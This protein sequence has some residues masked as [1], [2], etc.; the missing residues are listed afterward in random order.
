LVT[1]SRTRSCV[2]ASTWSGELR[3]RDTVAVETPARRA[4]SFA[5]QRRSGRA[6]PES[7]EARAVRGMRRS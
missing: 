7:I 5:L 3:T 1:A 6:E 2:R 4:T